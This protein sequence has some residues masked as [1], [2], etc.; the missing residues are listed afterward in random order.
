L[1]KQFTL[2][3]QERLKSRKLI[4]QLFKE[5]KSFAMAPFRVYYLSVESAISSLQFGVGVGTKNFKKAVDRNRVKRL[6]REAYRLQKITLQE[7][8]QTKNIQ[9]NLF[10]IYTAKELPEYKDVYK[11][12]GSILKKLNEIPDAIK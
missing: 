2:G 11:K 12:M 4:E 6:T 7:K 9:L 1:A 5:G 3:K 8:L 10:F